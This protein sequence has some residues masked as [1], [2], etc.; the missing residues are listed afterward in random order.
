VQLSEGTTAANN[1]VAT[2]SKRIA[3]ASNTVANASKKSQMQA[4]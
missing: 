1:K 2:P 4:K 3:K